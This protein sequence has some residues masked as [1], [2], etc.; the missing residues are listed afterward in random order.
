MSRWAT[1][2]CRSCYATV[3]WA[4]TIHGGRMCFDATPAD[5]DA[6]KAAR[7]L[8]VLIE[9]GS[10]RPLAQLAAM[11]D[12]DVVRSSDLYRPHNETCPQADSW[13]GSR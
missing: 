10:S 11:S 4:S 3:V 6:K 7:A 5:D 13:R 2:T 12:P 9:Q 8:H 1:A